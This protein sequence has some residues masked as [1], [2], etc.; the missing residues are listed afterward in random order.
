[1]TG[2]YIITNLINGKRYIGQSIDIRRRFWDHR[3]VSHETNRHLRFALNKYGKEAFKYEVLEECE[4]DRLNE[5]EM[6]WIEKLEP[7]YNAMPGGQGRG[8]KHSEETIEILREAGRRSWAAK[9]EE[10]KAKI[11]E[12]QLKGPR[13]GHAVTEETRQKIREKLT[14][15]KESPETKEKRKAT[16]AEKRRRGYVQTNEGHKKRVICGETGEVFESV[17]Q[18]AETIGINPSN[19][20]A[21]L[22]GRQ[23]TAKGFHFC[24]LEV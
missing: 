4:A 5:R 15:R 23:E 13:P 11:R 7:E 20:S 19:I 17:K 16:M 14:G 24:Y 12:T 6:Y 18:A 9:T 10:E 2:I 22:K 3:C 8:R 1:M 21:V